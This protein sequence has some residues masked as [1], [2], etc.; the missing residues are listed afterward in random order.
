[1][2]VL[3]TILY[4]LVYIL[5][6]VGVFK[7]RVKVCSIDQTIDQLQCS[8]KSMV[9]FGDAEISIIEGRTTQFQE[10]SNQLAKR[11]SEILKCQNDKI[12]VGIPDIFESLELYTPKSRKFWKEHLFFS[13]RTYE[14]YCNFDVCYANA[15]FSRIYYIFKDKESAKGW[16]SKIKE[17]WEGRDVVLVEGEATHTG[18][19]NDLLNGV[20]SIERI[21]CP[22]K[23]AYSAYDQIRD[24]CLK[25]DRDK[26][27]L[28]AVGNTA[29]LLVVDLVE[30]GYRAIDIGNL[31]MEYEWYLRKAKGKDHLA[32]HDIIGKEQNL[33][34][35]YNEYWNQVREIIASNQ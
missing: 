34:A 20:N 21:L 6:R 14:K 25:V 32:K 22:S 19:G 16:V 29:K 23:N 13:R 1:M 7:N 2:R 3:K 24:A 31:D 15:F 18:V 9:R 11:L 35:G 33:E 12:I 4:E 17:I 10:S 30:A 5:H 8:D 28:V 26:L 27:F